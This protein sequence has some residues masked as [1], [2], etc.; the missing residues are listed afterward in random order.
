MRYSAWIKQRGHQTSTAAFSMITSSSESFDCTT[1][2]WFL[3][4]LNCLFRNDWLFLESGFG[5]MDGLSSE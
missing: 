1:D 3:D 4:M 2:N 5:L